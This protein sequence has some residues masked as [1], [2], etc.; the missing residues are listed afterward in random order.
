MPRT[1]K[2]LKAVTLGGTNKHEE[3]SEQKMIIL[4]LGEMLIHMSH[5]ST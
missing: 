2:I 1:I 5:I 3:K 4:G